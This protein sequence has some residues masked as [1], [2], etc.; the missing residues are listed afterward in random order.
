MLLLWSCYY[1]DT[2][3]GGEPFHGSFAGIDEFMFVREKPE[4]RFDDD[5]VLI[6]W[7]INTFRS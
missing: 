6:A 5:D 4:F 7:W 3:T 2:R 1:P